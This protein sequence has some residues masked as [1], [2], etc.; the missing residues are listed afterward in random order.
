MFQI[1]GYRTLTTDGLLTKMQPAYRK[2]HSTET[3]LVRVV[4]D[5]HQASNNECEAV[6]MLLDLSAAFDAMDPT[7]LLDRHR[8]RYGFCEM[9]LRWI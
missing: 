8:D 5:I 4:N 2:H 6:L 9:V 7:I 3:A 1:E